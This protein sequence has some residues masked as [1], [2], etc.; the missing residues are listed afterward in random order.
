[1]SDNNDNY[2]PYSYDLIKDDNYEEPKDATNAFGY[3]RN[4]YDEDQVVQENEQ[5]VEE[6][7]PK[8]LSLEELEEIRTAAYDD[9]FEEGK[10]LG[11]KEGLAK[12]IADGEVKGFEEGKQKGYSEGLLLGEQL[13]TEQ[14]TKL[15]KYANHLVS[16]IEDLEQETA[17]ELIYLASRLAKAFIKDEL[18]RSP[19]YMTKMISEVSRLLPVASNVLTIRLNPQDLSLI[20]TAIHNENIVFE[21]DPSLNVGDIQAFSGMSSIDIQIEE[22]IDNYLAEFLSLNNDKAAVAKNDIPY[23]VDNFVNNAPAH[24]IT[25]TTKLSSEVQENPAHLNSNI[26]QDQNDLMRDGIDNDSTLNITGNSNTS[27]QVALSETVNETDVE[28][29]NANTSQE[30]VSQQQ[31]DSQVITNVQPQVKTA[32]QAGISP[33]KPEKSGI[34]FANTK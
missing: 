17:S 34:S 20:K 18:T 10:E 30:I 28:S 25:A 15:G 24:Q 19:K 13:I 21:Q 32:S 23:T 9:G 7:L 5:K 4:W 11:Y 31:V 2:I 29:L 12:G 26:S 1:M 14:A 16:A 33:A 22:R 27:E 3:R 6:E 8:G